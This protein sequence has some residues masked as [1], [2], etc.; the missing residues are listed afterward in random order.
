MREEKEGKK[1][2]CKGKNKL[3]T[4]KLTETIW[5]LPGKQKSKLPRKGPQLGQ[6]SGR[7]RSV[8]MS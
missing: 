7:S 1:R 2:K 3:K 6:K 8:S 5:G 4:Q